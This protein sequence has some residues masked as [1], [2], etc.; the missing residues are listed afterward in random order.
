MLSTSVKE[1]N[2]VDL[3]EVILVFILGSVVSN[4]WVQILKKLRK[5]L[6][7]IAQ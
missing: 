7:A 2:N 6:D 4:F 1:E 3:N 5:L